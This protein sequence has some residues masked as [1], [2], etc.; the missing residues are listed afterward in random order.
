MP[1]I[2]LLHGY[3]NSSY[4]YPQSHRTARNRLCRGAGI[5]GSGFS[6]A[7]STDDYDYTFSNL[8]DT[9][10]AFLAALQVESFFLLVTD[11]GT[12]GEPTSQRASRTD[13]WPG[14]RQNGNA[15]DEGLGP[16]WDA[17]KAFFADPTEANG[18][19]APSG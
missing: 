4:A 14:H 19:A 13:P 3:P 8:A 5:S 16:D 7:P 9:I 18:Q 10:D 1:A 11:F 6:S 15:H 17:P 2:L 12:P